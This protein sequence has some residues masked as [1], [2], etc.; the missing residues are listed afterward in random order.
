MEPLVQAAMQQE[1]S[2]QAV[3]MDA[4]GIDV[5]DQ[6]LNIAKK[7]LANIWEPV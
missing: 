1:S 4:L 5:D 6:A 7:I 3:Q 2:R